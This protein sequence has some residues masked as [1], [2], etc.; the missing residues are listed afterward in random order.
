MIRGPNYIDYLEKGPLKRL[1]IQLSTHRKNSDRDHSGEL[2]VTEFR[3]L[4]V[5][6]DE[7]IAVSVATQ[8][9][10]GDSK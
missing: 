6:L 3:C 4:H 9:V 5:D 7:I 1:R 10:K 8:L 2:K